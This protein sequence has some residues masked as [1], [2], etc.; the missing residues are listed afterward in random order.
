MYSKEEA[1]NVRQQF[2][3]MFGKRY[4]RKWLLYDTKL[5][6]INLKFSFEDRR[7]L[8]SIDITH[9]DTIFRAYY[10]EKLI[11]LKNIMK[12]EVSEEL[13]FEENYILESGKTISRVFVMYEG[14]KIQKQTDWP[15]VYEFFYTYMD[16]L[17]SFFREYKDF[18]DD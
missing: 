2:W 18:I 5:K 14:V 4:D 16:R 9:D 8:V 13:I 1:K 11:S 7:A 15:E 3:T 6:D 12:E 10:Y 17:E